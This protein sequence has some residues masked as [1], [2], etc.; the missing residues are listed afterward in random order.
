MAQKV[1]LNSLNIDQL[2]VY[3]DKAVKERNTGMRVTFTGVGI[4]AAGYIASVIWSATTSLE[5]FYVLMT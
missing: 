4:A 2:N 5:D 1:N 3:K